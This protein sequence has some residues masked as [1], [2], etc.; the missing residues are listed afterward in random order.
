MLSE[1]AT[2]PARAGGPHDPAAVARLGEL[3]AFLLDLDGTLVLGDRRNHGLSPLPG[4]VELV[5]TLHK[6]GVAVGV[7][8]NGTARPPAAQ[9][10]VLRQ[11]G[12]DLDDDAVLTPASSAA[13]VCRRAGHRRV[14]VLGG[15]GVSGPLVDAGIEVVPPEGR[16][17]VDAVLVGWFREFGMDH[18]EAAANAVWGGAAFYSASQS[19]FFASAEGRAIGTS[20]AICA[21]ITD[22]TGVRPTI[23]G[24]PS[25]AALRTAAHRLGVRRRRDLAVVGDDPELEVPMALRGGAFAVAVNSGTG[26]AGS[27]DHLAPNRRPHLVVDGV[28]ELLRL[29]RSATG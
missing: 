18:L 25:P 21:V 4:A 24:K 16:P 7:L 6:D 22:L 12:F 15:E 27:F 26:H 5:D 23:V 3:R 8:T 2:T 19:L 14:M 20:R 9:A 13:E 17:S 28:D 29:Y 10:G 1:P 11:I